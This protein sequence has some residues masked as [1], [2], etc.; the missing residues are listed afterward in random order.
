MFT[1]EKNVEVPKGRSGKPEKYPFPD[2]DSGDSFFA[3]AGKLTASS[4][5]KSIASAAIRRMGAGAFT[6]RVLT[7]DGVE[8]VRVW[9]K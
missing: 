7:E 3:P 8:G 9:R 5:Q 1:V 6:T 2:M 4:L